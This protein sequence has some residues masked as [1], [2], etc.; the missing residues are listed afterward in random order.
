MKLVMR[1]IREQLSPHAGALVTRFLIAA[2]VAATPYAFSFLGKWLVDEALQVSGA[3]KAN[4]VGVTVQWK[5]KSQ[6]EKLRL[7]G[8]FL[9]AS[10]GIHAA[11]TALSTLSEFLNSRMTNRMAYELRSGVYEKIERLDM[12]VFSREQVGQLMTRV[13]DDAGAIPGNLA[14]LVINSATQLAMLVLGLYL[15]TRLNVKMTFVALAAL[16]FYAVTCIAFLPRL[17]DNTERIRERGALFNGHVIERL[18][19]VLTVKNYAQENREA[20][21]FAEK[22]GENQTLG[23]SQ[24]H[25]NLGFSTLT[26]LIT[27]IGTLSVLAFGFLN[28]KA[29]RMQL[30]EVLAFYQVTAQLFVPIA[31][32]VSMAT[33]AQTLQVLAFRV[34]S[35]MDTPSTVKPPEDRVQL[36]EIR[37]DISFEHVSLRYQEGGPFALQDVSVTIPAGSTA[38]IVGPTGCGKSSLLTLLNRLY[39][40]EEGAIRLD[41]V[42]VRQLPVTQLR[43]AIGNVLHDCPVFT[44]T[45][46][47][48]IAYG[49]PDASRADVEAAAK[50]VEL[51]DAAT[52]LPGGYDTSLGS[53]GTA[54]NAELLTKLALARALLTRPAVLTV[55]DTYATIEEHVE[56]R[57]RSAI[58]EALR[59]RTILIATS[60]L[61]ICED[62]DMVIVMSNGRVEQVGSHSE[63]LSVPGIYRRMYMRQV[64]MEDVGMD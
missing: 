50:Q 45:L 10:L 41:G 49:A 46:A 8:V 51:H 32:L 36:D 55:D 58:R 52:A 12:A 14:N 44:G 24:H 18:A 64:G 5:A 31:A 39:E 19:N 35:I 34:Y 56:A 38:C 25:L 57:L 22:L 47:E 27:A 33:V 21:L 16:P 1:L 26:T 37:G 4:A 53:G 23:R 30:G 11:A 62:A 48:N 59:G 42:D 20:A 3:P 6:E 43:R 28:I 40:W 7:L 61:S 54:L 60:R 9:V 2:L 13:M 17:K 63:L 29:N 15:L